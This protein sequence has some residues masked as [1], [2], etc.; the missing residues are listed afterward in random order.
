MLILILS[1]YRKYCDFGIM[2]V[3][4]CLLQSVV[5]WCLVSDRFL[6]CSGGSPFSRLP[7]HSS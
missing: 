5:V 7:E 3:M 2:G 1:L 4:V 6:S